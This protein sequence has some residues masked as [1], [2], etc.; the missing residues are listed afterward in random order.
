MNA[1]DCLVVFSVCTW[2]CFRSILNI[3][4]SLSSIKSSLHFTGL[5]VKGTWASRSNSLHRMNDYVVCSMCSIYYCT[6][7][8]SASLH[9]PGLDRNDHQ[10]WEKKVGKKRPG[11]TNVYSSFVNFRSM[12]I[13]QI[14][15]FFLYGVS[16]SPLNVDVLR[17]A[18]LSH[19]VLDLVR[20]EPLLFFSLPLLL[21][22]QYLLLLLLLRF[23]IYYLGQA[24]R[25]ILPFP[26]T[27]QT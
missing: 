13:K 7:Q 17:N 22:Y 16:A 3:L 25:L 5:T 26:G 23:N 14:M 8:H 4:S 19:S 6:I 21:F 20:S 12:Q 15:V 24:S 11:Q 9:H 18:V 10:T 27:H 2:M 1:S